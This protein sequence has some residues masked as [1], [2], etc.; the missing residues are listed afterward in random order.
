MLISA[1]L[2]SPIA[3]LGDVTSPIARNAADNFLGEVQYSILRLFVLL[4]SYVV[5][6]IL[7]I[8]RNRSCSGWVSKSLIQEG[9]YL[10]ISL[11]L[12]KLLD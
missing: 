11:L 5:L 3:H 2:I 6:P 4:S 1:A 7:F 10:T 9:N 8:R 12:R